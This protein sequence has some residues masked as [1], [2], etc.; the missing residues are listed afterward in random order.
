MQRE[1]YTGKLYPLQDNVME[2]IGSLNNAFYLTGGTALGRYY[3]KHRFSDDLD[4]FVNRDDNFKKYCNEFIEKLKLRYQ[5]DFE[6]RA[7]DFVRFNIISDEV[8]LKTELINDVAYHHGS[9]IQDRCRI[10]NIENILSNKI[11]A[12]SR[13]LSKD[14]ADILFISFKHKFNWIDIFDAAKKK[15]AWVNEIEIANII[16]RF[17]PESL[18]K[19]NWIVQEEA[20]LEHRDKFHIIAKDILKG[21]DNS[22]F[23]PDD[24]Y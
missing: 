2:I 20:I 23:N 3:L 24:S 14:F 22:L 8:N 17:D 19:L 18:L 7:K 13:N 16:D 6:I 1:Y 4:F 10:D 5:I 12:V 15:D 21:G 9:F 11:S